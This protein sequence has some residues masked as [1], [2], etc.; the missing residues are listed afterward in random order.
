[1]KM[2]DTDL[3]APDDLVNHEKNVI[4][5]L[6]EDSPAQTLRFD[7]EAAYEQMQEYLRPLLGDKSPHSDA[8][9]F[10]TCLNVMQASSQSIGAGKAG[11]MVCVQAVEEQELWKEK[12]PSLEAWKESIDFEGQ[13]KS[14]FRTR[15]DLCKTQKACYT[16]ICTLWNAEP[17][18][19]FRD[20]APLPNDL[21]RAW[22]Q[23][24]RS[25]LHEAR[26]EDKE[27]VLQLIKAVYEERVKNCTPETAPSI[28]ALRPVD[29][30][31]ARK[32]LQDRYA[33]TPSWT[34]SL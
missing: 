21:G 26:A 3:I 34:R 29:F 24:L 28:R 8:Q 20:I 17:R 12:F 11:L 4:A 18:T 27:K 31:E 23:S 7:V 1:M 19:I 33:H 32:M 30:Y 14:L 13:I 15:S 9:K 6:V 16:R 22:L 2:T 10:N 25:L 5:R